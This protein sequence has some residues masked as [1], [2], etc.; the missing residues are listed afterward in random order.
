MNDN[1]VLYINKVS[2]EGRRLIIMT[3][4]MLYIY[5]YIYNVVLYINKVSAEGR[6]LII[7]Q[8]ICNASSF[9]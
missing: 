6:R 7:I 3:T 5:I 4:I 8:D 2:A 9:R 1:V